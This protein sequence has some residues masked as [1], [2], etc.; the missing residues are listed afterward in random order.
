[1]AENYNGVHDTPDIGTSIEDFG[2]YYDDM[3]G[4]YIDD[5]LKSDLPGSHL[6]NLL[7]GELPGSHLDVVLESPLPGGST[8]ELLAGPL[9][10]GISYGADSIGNRQENK[11]ASGSHGHHQ[12][13]RRTSPAQSGSYGG[14]SAYAGAG[15]RKQE[16]T[17]K[18]RREKLD[19]KLRELKEEQNRKEYIASLEQTSLHQSQETRDRINQEFRKGVDDLDTFWKYLQKNVSENRERNRQR[20]EKRSSTPVSTPL[21]RARNSSGFA[22]REIRKENSLQMYC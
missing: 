6:D 22:R 3:P 9:P 20:R 18:S 17:G 4:R 16:N 19:E 10:G 21:E 7:Y 13:Q 14:G 15:K 2:L 8:D 12:A 11:K 1:M 5:I